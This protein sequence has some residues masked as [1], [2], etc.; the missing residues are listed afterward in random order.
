M[1]QEFKEFPGLRYF[2]EHNLLT[3]HPTGVLEDKIL[4]ELIAFIHSL[5]DSI[6]E[7]FDRFSDLSGLVDIKVKFGHAFQIAQEQQSRK[8]GRRLKSI[9]H[10]ERL[11]GL[12][13]SRMYESLMHSAEIDVRVAK[14]RAEAAEW[15][16]VPQSVLEP[17]VIQK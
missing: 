2:P 13:M 16:G 17:P 7:P 4:D 15:L 10:S 8:G 12:G 6:D 5:E 3:W 9:L 1:P 11:V 14:N